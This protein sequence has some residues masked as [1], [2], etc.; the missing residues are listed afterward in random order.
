MERTAEKHFVL[1]AR[2]SPIGIAFLIAAKVVDMEDF[3][4]LLG[5]VG[6]YFITVLIGLA[7]HGAIVLPFIYFILVRK[8]PYTFIYGIS[9]ALAT[10]FGTSS[11]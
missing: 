1:H 4:V 3:S 7:I 10:A 6:L 2:Y 9:Q 11:R 8:N 5:K